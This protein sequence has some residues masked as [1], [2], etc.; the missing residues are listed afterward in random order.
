MV[1][2]VA[3]ASDARMEVSPANLGYQ[4]IIVIVVALA[5]EQ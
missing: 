4:G 5:S 3:V 2:L 1:L